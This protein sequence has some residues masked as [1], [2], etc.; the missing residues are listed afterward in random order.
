MQTS[1]PS[2]FS[3]WLLHSWKPLASASRGRVPKSDSWARVD[4]FQG[5][6]K[7]TAV[8]FPGP[9]LSTAERRSPSVEIWTAGSFQGRRWLDGTRSL[10]QRL[11]SKDLPVAGDSHSW[12]RRAGWHHFNKLHPGASPPCPPA[13]SFFKSPTQTFS[14]WERRGYFTPGLAGEV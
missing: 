5:P 9:Q 4:C 1:S 2:Q 3:T 14:Y 10:H 8:H 13:L 7:P 11:F 6:T 12:C